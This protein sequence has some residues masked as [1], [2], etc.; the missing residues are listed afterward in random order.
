MFAT[1]AEEAVARTS[2]D[3]AHESRPILGIAG[4]QEVAVVASERHG[5]GGGD[6]DENRERNLMGAGAQRGGNRCGWRGE[7]G[8][9]GGVGAAAGCA[10]TWNGVIRT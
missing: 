2:C 5:F 9:V 7:R 4:G 1:N 8:W 6:L 3:V 10:E